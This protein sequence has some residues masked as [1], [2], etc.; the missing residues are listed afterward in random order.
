MRTAVRIRTVSVGNT[1]SIPIPQRFVAQIGM[2][3]EVKVELG[4]HH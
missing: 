4:D 3:A 2:P 1:V